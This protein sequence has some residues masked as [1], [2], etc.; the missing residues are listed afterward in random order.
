[1][2]IIISSSSSSI[3]ISISIIRTDLAYQSHEH[4]HNSSVT[5]LMGQNNTPIAVFSTANCE[6]NSVSSSCKNSTLA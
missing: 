2:I 1:M 3:I 5:N 4:Q 6:Q